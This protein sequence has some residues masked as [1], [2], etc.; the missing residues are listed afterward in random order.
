MLMAECKYCK[1][2]IE[3]QMEDGRWKKLDPDSGEL[4]V[5]HNKQPTQRDRPYNNAYQQGLPKELQFKNK[6]CKD[7]SSD[8]NV[9]MVHWENI[10][11]YTEGPRAGEPRWQ[12]TNADGTKHIHGQSTS[13]KDTGTVTVDTD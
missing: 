10:G 12:L 13:K 7:C 2:K 4:H 11:K 5:C 6:P 9:V 8:F 1:E 3:W